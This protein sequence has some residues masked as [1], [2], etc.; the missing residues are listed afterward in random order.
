MEFNAKFEFCDQ[1]ESSPRLRLNSASPK[2]RSR[3][4]YQFVRYK[5][6]SSAYCTHLVDSGTVSLKSAT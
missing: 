3:A 4:V 1:A 2:A 5:V 6:V